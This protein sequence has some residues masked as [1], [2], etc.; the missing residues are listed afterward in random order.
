MTVESVAYRPAF[1]VSLVREGIPDVSLYNEPAVTQN[2]FG[3][4]CRNAAK[5]I[6]D[7]QRKSR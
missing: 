2:V 3:Q 4:K 5:G 1:L 6:M 7:R